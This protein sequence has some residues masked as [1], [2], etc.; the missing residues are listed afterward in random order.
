[1][2]QPLLEKY[3]LQLELTAPLNCM[4]RAIPSVLENADIEEL[5]NDILNLDIS[6]SPDEAV[7]ETIITTMLNHVCD[8]ATVDMSIDEMANIL[9]QLEAS[10]LDVSQP[11]YSRIWRSLDL[12]DLNKLMNSDD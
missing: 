5:V 7:G 1:V 6:G 4:V 3:A 10:G 12:D 8:I 11:R 2:L 9:R